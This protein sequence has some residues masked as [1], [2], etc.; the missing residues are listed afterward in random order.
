FYQAVW[1]LVNAGEL[2]PA[3]SFTS[4]RAALAYRTSRYGGGIPLDQI[5]CLFS[6]RIEDPPFSSRAPVDP[7]NFLQSLACKKLHPGILEAIEQALGCFRRGLY[8]PAT[9]MLA[10]AAEATWTEC[11]TAVAKKLG[12]TKLE[13]VVN[14]PLASISKKVMEIQK[15]LA[16]PDGKV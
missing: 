8:M 2:F 3:E 4:W 7:D 15:A 11:G 10:A 14:D 5:C 13:A 9:A 1:E 16:Q 6:H 12:N